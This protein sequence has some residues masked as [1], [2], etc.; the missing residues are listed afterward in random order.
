MNKSQIGIEEPI[1]TLE[2]NKF[3]GGP[4]VSRKEIAHQPPHRRPKS[5]RNQGRKHTLGTA[6]SDT[7][8]VASH[9]PTNRSTDNSPHDAADRC[10]HFNPRESVD[11]GGAWG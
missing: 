10:S 4:H 11:F 9:Q 5:Y 8:R 7:P 1:E 2:A 3:N 6:A